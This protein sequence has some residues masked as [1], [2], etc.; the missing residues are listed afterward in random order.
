MQPPP[1]LTWQAILNKMLQKDKRLR[2]NSQSVLA[3][4]WFSVKGHSFGR[5]PS[6]TIANLSFTASRNRARQI[7]L[8]ALAVKLEDEHKKNCSSSSTGSPAKTLVPLTETNSEKRWQG[9]LNGNSGILFWPRMCCLICSVS[10]Y[11]HLGGLLDKAMIVDSCWS[12]LWTWL[13][14]IAFVVS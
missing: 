6:L 10:Q 14:I 9:W 12:D 5:L 2:P 3:D 11:I 1:F 7:L 8:N 4:P 13:R